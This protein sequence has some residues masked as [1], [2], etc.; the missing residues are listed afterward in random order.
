MACAQP[1]PSLPRRGEDADPSGGRLGAPC[2][3]TARHIRRRSRAHEGGGTGA[4]VAHAG[5]H[6]RADPRREA[7]R[8]RG[9]SGPG[10]APDRAVGDRRRRPHPHRRDAVGEAALQRHRGH[11]RG[12]RTQAG[13]S[14]GGVAQGPE[15]AS[16][17]AHCRAGQRRSGARVFRPHHGPDRRRAA[18]L[19]PRRRDP[20]LAR[21]HPP[22]LRLRHDHRLGPGAH[23]R[24][25]VRAGRR[26]AG[27]GDHLSRRHTA[28]G[29][30]RPLRQ[31]VAHRPRHRRAP[32]RGRGGAAG[33]GQR[34]PRLSGRALVALPAQ[35]GGA[36]LRLRRHV[37][38]C[39][40]GG[41][42][43]RP[44][45]G[46][47]APGDGRDGRSGQRQRVRAHRR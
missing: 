36:R 32:A 4:V 24:P 18:R 13:G 14:R 26:E 30:A 2:A 15:P 5:A 40:G 43:A 47:S 27:A 11:R 39:A 44:R 3:R 37:E 17:R 46:R 6:A 41:S 23:G 16:R 20:R 12:S 33:A 42:Q 7:R 19:V 31:P 28:P 10:R 9:E 45:G 34:G 38:G 29:G 1:P 35:G 25:G 8:H 22:R 21:Q